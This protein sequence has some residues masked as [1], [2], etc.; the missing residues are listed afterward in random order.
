[1]KKRMVYK[2]VLAVH[3]A[4]QNPV[5]DKASQTRRALLDE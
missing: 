1:M 4:H 5:K 2:N 3:K